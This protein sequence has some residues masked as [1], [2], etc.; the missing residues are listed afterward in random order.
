MNAM[1]GEIKINVENE[2]VDGG[3]II[4]GRMKGWDI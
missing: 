3:N 2:S 1:G 4:D